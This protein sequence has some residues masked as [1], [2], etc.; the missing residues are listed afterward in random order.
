MMQPYHDLLTDILANGEDV[1]DRT[2]V[3]TRRVF[4]RQMR[5]DLGEGF[6]AITTKRLMWRAMVSELLWFLEGSQDERR[7]A[8]I[9][10]G[11]RDSKLTTIWTDNAQAPHW[12]DRAQYYG[13]LGRVYGQMWRFWPSD[14]ARFAWIQRR[15]REVDD[16]IV[17][18]P[19]LKEP[20]VTDSLTGTYQGWATHRSGVGVYGAPRAKNQPRL[21]NRIYQLWNTMISRC[22]DTKHPSYHQYGGRGVTVS[23]EWQNFQ[24]FRTS[25]RGVPGFRDWAS[26]KGYHLDKD[27]FG[28]NQYAKTTTI[29]I[30]GRPSQGTVTENGDLLW[31]RQY[32]VDQVANLVHGI[33]TN[34]MDRRHILSAWNPGELDQMALPPCHAMSQYFV[35]GNGRLSCHMYQRSLDAGLGG[36]FNIASYALLT[37]MLAQVCDLG[38][39]ELIMSFGDCHIYQ[40][41][42]PAIQQQLKRDHYP[43]PSLQ[44][45]PK[46]KS[47]FGFKM[48]DIELIGYRCHPTIKMNMAV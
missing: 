1:L 15:D 8:E 35:S 40:N 3:G 36:P 38:V 39:G 7:L 31:R 18:A 25:I 5:F 2:G 12:Q 10:H 44:L 30:P 9:L 13:D 22:Y 21:E 41:H 34:P 19:D 26:K 16:L 28:A 6:P 42:I 23:T 43:P 29:F 17:S 27:H 33:K 32:H 46:V 37:H 11:S 20:E 14:P 47:I 48:Q 24:S 4:G 45:N